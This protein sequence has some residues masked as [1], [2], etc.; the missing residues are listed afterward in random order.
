MHW[1][2]IFEWSAKTFIPRLF[3]RV[4]VFLSTKVFLV[5]NPHLILKEGDGLSSIS[6]FWN[7]AKATS[8]SAAFSYWAENVVLLG[9]A[10]EELIE[11]FF[12]LFFSGDLVDSWR[13]S[14]GDSRASFKIFGTRPIIHHLSQRSLGLKLHYFHA[15][16]VGRVHRA[17]REDCS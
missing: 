11:S 8:F 4:V 12:G 10:I 5:G 15:G 1:L 2:I 9:A 14:R 13:N 6:S 7:L 17:H 16:S 3:S